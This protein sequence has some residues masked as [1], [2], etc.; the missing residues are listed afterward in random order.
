MTTFADMTTLLLTFFVLLLSFAQMDIVK[1][2]R[3]MGSIR[4]AFG[5]QRIEVGEFFSMSTEPVQI[6][7]YQKR[8]SVIE[9]YYADMYEAIKKAIEKADLSDSVEVLVSN[10]GVIVRAK[11]KVLFDLGKAELKKGAYPLLDK[12]VSLM[13]QFP[14]YK[15][16][17][18]GHTDDLP[19]NTP[20]FPSNWELSSAR[21]TRVLRYFISKGIPPER[22]IAVGYGETRPLVP[23][24]S[25]KN[26]AKNRRVEFVFTLET[27]EEQMTRRLKEILEQLQQQ[28]AALKKGKGGVKVPRDGTGQGT[29]K[30]GGPK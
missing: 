16:A 24:D 23:N 8:D 27:D 28:E 5:V 15:L 1:F 29:K 22:L 2:R 26:R 30:S 12:L 13:K 6:F 19:I 7:D 17:I 11:E 9:M 20:R 4:E 18:E 14:R 10:R 21:A 3:I 25:P